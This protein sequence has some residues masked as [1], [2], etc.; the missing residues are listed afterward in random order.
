MYFVKLKLEWFEM[1]VGT[2]GMV[3]LLRLPRGDT[4]N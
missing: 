4:H 1:A 3:V 2:L